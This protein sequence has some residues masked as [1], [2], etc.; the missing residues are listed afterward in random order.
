MAGISLQERAAQLQLRGPTALLVAGLALVGLVAF[1]LIQGYVLPWTGFGEKHGPEGEYL[2]AKTLWDWM[3]LF[4]IPLV[5]A[6]GVLWFNHWRGKLEGELEIARSDEEALQDYLDRMTELMLEKGLRGS[7]EDAELR[8][9]ARARTLTL[10]WRL[11]R[12]RRK[13]A[14]RFLHEAGLIA[15]DAPVIVLKGAHL[16]R[17]EL[18]ETTLNVLT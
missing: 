16:M 17:A 6:G 12:E 8:H 4:I 11:R 13:A 1:A 3:E 10:L 14:L 15:R 9:I 18:N 2:C 7:K 5:L